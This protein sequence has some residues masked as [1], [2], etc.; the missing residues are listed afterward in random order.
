MQQ[1][2]NQLPKPYVI[3]GDMNTKST[4]LW[5]QS[6]NAKGKIFE[7]QLAEEDLVI[8]DNDSA[9]PYHVRVKSYSVVYLTI[10]SAAASSNLHMR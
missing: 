3:M 1:L 10:Y 8:I 6:I 7:E 2:I 9:T 5:E 4:M